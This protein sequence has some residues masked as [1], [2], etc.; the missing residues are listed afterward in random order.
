MIEA[1][2]STMKQSKTTK[3]LQ[4]HMESLPVPEKV[5][6]V[7]DHYNRTG[8]YRPEELRRVLGSPNQG[9]SM[10]SRNDLQ[11]MLNRPAR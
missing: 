11:Q 10:G 1:R 3:S 9:V 5:R 6:R 4:E 8:T 7:V 2:G